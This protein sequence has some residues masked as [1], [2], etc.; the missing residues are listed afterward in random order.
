MDGLFNGWP[1]GEVFIFRVTQIRLPTE[2]FVF[3]DE[4]ESS[5]DDGVFGI[6]RS[7]SSA[8]VNL[9]SDR[10][11][12]GAGLAF[13]DGHSVRWKWKAPKKFVSHFTPASGDQDL[14]DLRRLQAAVP[15]P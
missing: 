15:P 1:P 3:I 5:I 6:Y 11:S 2:V 13:A 14:Y 8:W 12:G 9:P 4:N 10:H 7:P